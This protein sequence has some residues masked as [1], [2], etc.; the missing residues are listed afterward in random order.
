MKLKIVDLKNIGG[1]NVGMIIVGKFFEIFVKVLYIY[2]DIVGLVFFEVFE[3]YK[4]F[5]GFGYGVCL[6]VCFF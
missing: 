4:G 3:N 1:F 5:G 6:F 2:M